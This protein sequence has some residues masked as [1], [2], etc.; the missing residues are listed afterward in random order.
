MLSKYGYKVQ[1]FHIWASACTAIWHLP[2]RFPVK[3]LSNKRQNII[4]FLTKLCAFLKSWV[5]LLYV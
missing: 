2:E 4:S 3:I 1:T 5:F